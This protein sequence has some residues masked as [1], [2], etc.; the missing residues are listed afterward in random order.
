MKIALSAVALALLLTGCSSAPESPDST[1][2]REGCRLEGAGQHMPALVAKV[3]LGMTL[4]QV[5]HLL[6]DIDYTPVAGQHYF[7][8][9][10]DCPLDDRG[11]H[12]AACGVV[13]DFNDYNVEPSVIRDTLQACW[14]GALGE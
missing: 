3:R 2:S 11:I 1:I 14:W 9:V 10:G 12:Q 4:A 8:T 6:G 5:Q 7:S 13:A